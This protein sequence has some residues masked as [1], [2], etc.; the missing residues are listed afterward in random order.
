M[1]PNAKGRFCSSCTKTVVD[2]TNKTDEEI[3]AVFR[4]EGKL[5][6]R[7]KKTQL[8][9]LTFTI[10]KHIIQQRHSF[11]SSFLLAIFIV[12][13]TT[14]LSCT[15]MDG[16]PQVIDSIVIIDANEVKETGHTIKISD[17]LQKTCATALKDSSDH[18]V[19]PK[20][21]ALIHEYIEDDFITMG[22]PIHEP[23][24]QDTVEEDFILGDIS[25]PTDSIGIHT[26]AIKQP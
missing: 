12:M 8:E 22:I 19:P 6:G 9:G 24:P 7:F 23:I 20:P 2:F 10:P 1:T 26:T 14:L 15:N 17:T 13:G 5:C 18:H 4:K 21:P 16:K 3:Q 25:M 11:R